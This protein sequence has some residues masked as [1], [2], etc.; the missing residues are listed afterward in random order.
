MNDKICKKCKHVPTIFMAYDEKSF[1]IHCLPFNFPLHEDG[2]KIVEEVYN[3][4][5]E[6]MNE[7]SLMY[8]KRKFSEYG[9]KCPSNLFKEICLNKNCPYYVEQT[10]KDWNTNEFR[11][12]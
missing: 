7:I 1:K 4:P 2:E 5:E 10:I 9:L 12:L 8:S 3:F 11:N 6:R